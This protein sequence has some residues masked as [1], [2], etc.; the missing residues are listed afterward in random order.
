MSFGGHQRR[1]RRPGYASDQKR[2]RAFV[3]AHL[4]QHG[5][6]VRR[7]I[8]RA[9]C[10]LCGHV[11]ELPISDWWADHVDPVAAGGTERGELRLSCKECQLRQ[12]S[13]VG[14]S[15][16]PLAQSRKRKPEPHPGRIN[17]SS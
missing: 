1:E 15:R 11:K 7:G 9:R 8:W 12:G 13:Q 6:Q 5:E 17:P 10:P 3:A 2:R 14:N 4:R 16:N